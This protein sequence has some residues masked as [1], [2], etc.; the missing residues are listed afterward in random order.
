MKFI[1]NLQEK[2]L[3]PDQR[4]QAAFIKLSNT[5]QEFSTVSMYDFDSTLGELARSLYDWTLWEGSLDCF[6]FVRDRMDIVFFSITTDMPRIN[7]LIPV[8]ENLTIPSI[9][10]YS[11]SSSVWLNSYPKI[12][13]QNIRLMNMS[14]LVLTDVKPTVSVFES[15]TKTPV[16]FAS[17]PSYFVSFRD[18]LTSIIAPRTLIICPDTICSSHNNFKNTLLNYLVLKGLLETNKLDS[19]LKFCVFGSDK[20]H[21]GKGTDIT[22]Q[23]IHDILGLRDNRLEIISE[24]INLDDMILLLRRACLLINLDSSLSQND[25]NIKAASMKVP[26]LTTPLAVGSDAISTTYPPYD[27][28]KFIEYGLKLLTNKEF[29]NEVTEQNYALLDKWSFSSV[30]SSLLPVLNELITDKVSEVPNE[31]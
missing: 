13:E 8:I 19:E 20:A 23:E 29:S 17:T 7:K 2:E 30:R 6:D 24:N 1:E 26:V 4:Y 27:I 9:C 3:Q 25:W 21:T 11:K 16:F 31:G 14:N 15:M 10:Y 22:E 18:N 28:D 5:T 12:V